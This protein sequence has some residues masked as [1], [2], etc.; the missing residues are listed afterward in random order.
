MKTAAAAHQIQ[1]H[2]RSFFVFSGT[3]RMCVD[4]SAA[5]GGSIL[6]CGA[7]RKRPWPVSGAGAGERVGLVRVSILLSGLLL[8]SS[9]GLLGFALAGADMGPVLV[10]SV[11]NPDGEGLRC[12]NRPRT[13]GIDRASFFRR[14]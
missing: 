11:A 6:A 5:G 2:S 12:D 3:D 1:R 10:D 8:C 4:L 14:F 7:P 13:S 9:S